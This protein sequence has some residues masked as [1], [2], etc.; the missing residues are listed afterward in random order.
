MERNKAVVRAFVDAINEREWTRLRHLVTD[1][2]VR[3]SHAAGQP[4]VTN[5]EEFIAFLVGE[6]ESFPDGHEEIKDLIAEGDRVA[7]RHRFTG[8][9]QGS[10]GGL[11][12]TGRSLE[13]Q[14][15]AIY[16]LADGLIAECWVEWDNLNGLRQ[17]GHID[18]GCAPFGE[19]AD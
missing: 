7:V 4:G 9:Q 17:L 8:T 3:H 12:A 15:L 2:I 14:Y 18:K 10:I 5:R 1:D 13:A 19:P 16:R 11:P 6:C